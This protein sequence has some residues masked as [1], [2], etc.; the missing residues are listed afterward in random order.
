[1]C[2]IIKSGSK[3]VENLNTLHDNEIHVVDS[4][5][6]RGL[7]KFI[8]FAS[9]VLISGEG[10]EENLKKQWP[11][12]GNFFVMQIREWSILNGNAIL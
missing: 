3:M 6:Q 9:K 5:F 8:F 11:K 10:R 4:P 12:T 2:L 1:M 7:K